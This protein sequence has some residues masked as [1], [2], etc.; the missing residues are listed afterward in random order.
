MILEKYL[1]KT[2]YLDP[3]TPSSDGLHVSVTLREV[4]EEPDGLFTFQPNMILQG[5]KIE[6]FKPKAK[7]LGGANNAP[8]PDEEEDNEDLDFKDFL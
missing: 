5:N 6:E 7:E 8:A 1:I 4:R 3:K 2:G